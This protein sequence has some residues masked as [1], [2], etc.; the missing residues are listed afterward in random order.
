MRP[1]LGDYLHQVYALI[2]WLDRSQGGAATL[3]YA[4]DAKLGSG[5]IGVYWLRMAVNGAYGR[6]SEPPRW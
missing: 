1:P 6:A 5:P 2:R 4:R 3:A